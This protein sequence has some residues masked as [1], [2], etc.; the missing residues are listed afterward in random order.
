MNE[1]KPIV[2]GQAQLSEIQEWIFHLDLHVTEHDLSHAGKALRSAWPQVKQYFLDEL[3]KQ[4]KENDALVR[5]INEYGKLRAADKKAIDKLTRECHDWWTAAKVANDALK[6]ARADGRREVD[7]LSLA[8]KR[9]QMRA[10]SE[11]QGE[12]LE[13]AQRD[14][15]I[16]HAIATKALESARDATED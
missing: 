3:Q 16:I 12:D 5:L 6:S 4:K 1:R 9:V 10:Y 13:D 8:L 2:S 7:I 14:L 15:R 11:S